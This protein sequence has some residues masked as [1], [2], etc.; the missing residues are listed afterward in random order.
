MIQL[1]ERIT[2]NLTCKNITV[3]TAHVCMYRER[4]RKNCSNI[5]GANLNGWDFSDVCPSGSCGP[6]L[7]EKF[8][9]V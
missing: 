2:N 4:K 6:E 7:S 1:S 9:C 8:R 3:L 5:S